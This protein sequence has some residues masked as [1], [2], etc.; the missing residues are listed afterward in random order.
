[1]DVF[2]AALTAFFC[3]ASGAAIGSLA[4]VLV[5]AAC[6]APAEPTRTPAPLSNTFESPAALARAVLTALER[7][8]LEG[9]RALPLSETEYREHVWPELPVSRPERNVPFDY[10]WGQ[11]KQRSDGSLQQTFARYAGKRLDLVETRF[12]G[13]TTTYTSFSVMR[14]SEI[15]ARDDSGR[16]LVLRLYGSA[17]AREGRFK[18]FSYVIDN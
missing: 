17:L 12:T 10:A 15:I 13:E 2:P 3:R 9:L 14:E 1:M 16:D 5:T 6:S 4:A 11:M 18:I 7:R 8:D